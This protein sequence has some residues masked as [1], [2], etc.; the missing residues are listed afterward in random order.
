MGASSEYARVLP[1]DTNAALELNAASELAQACTRLLRELGGRIST[2]SVMA[3]AVRLLA[4]KSTCG[5][6]EH[7]QLLSLRG[8]AGRLLNSLDALLVGTHETAER[9]LPPNRPPSTLRSL[10]ERLSRSTAIQLELSAGFARDS[11]E[12]QLIQLPGSEV[13]VEQVLMHLVRSRQSDWSD[14]VGI[15]VYLDSPQPG[16]SDLCFEI[17]C[18]LSL[19][20]CAERELECARALALSMGAELSLGEYA[21]RGDAVVLRLRIPVRSFTGCKKSLR[22]LLVDDRRIN[23]LVMAD[24][25][26]A[27]GHVVDLAGN[28]AEALELLRHQSFDAVL[29]DLNMPGMDGLELA[30]AIRESGEPASTLPV[31]LLVP[32]E[33]PAILE[34]AWIAGVSAVACKRAG[35]ERIMDI[36]AGHLPSSAQ[37]WGYTHDSDSSLMVH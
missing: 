26:S 35:A 37:L 18:E 20:A 29:T 32:Q 12:S 16:R 36:L 7:M 4:R 5:V 13:I 30:R 3:S 11:R 34:K 22:L 28:A 31:V 8:E 6:Q 14:P 19:S 27:G 1:V 15:D 25:F 2:A 17:G 21:R 9:S 33:S 24:E 23:R 10:F